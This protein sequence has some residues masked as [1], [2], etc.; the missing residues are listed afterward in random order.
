MSLA[1]VFIVLVLHDLLVVPASFVRRKVKGTVT[2]SQRGMDPQVPLFLED[3]TGRITSHHSPMSHPLIRPSA[4]QSICIRSI[5][6]IR[7]IRSIRPCVRRSAHTYIPPCA[8]H[9]LPHTRNDPPHPSPTLRCHHAC[10]GVMISVWNTTSH[11]L[12]ST[13]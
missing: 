9:R 11:T 10:T 5:R 1:L 2:L 4:D 8:S 12:R 13:Q 7:F 3:R 6:S